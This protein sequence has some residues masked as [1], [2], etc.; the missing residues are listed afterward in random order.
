MTRSRV[1]VA[2]GGL[3]IS[4]V[5]LWLA[6]RDADPDA[7][8]EALGDADVALVLLASTVFMVGYLL[9]AIRWRKIAAT[10]QVSTRRFYEM[11]LGGL[12]CNNVLP[13]RIG[14]LVRAGWLSREAP[15]PAGRALGTVAL[16]R[17]CDV[18]TL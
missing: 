10:Q 7:V 13:V 8:R 17:V 14:E 16:D 6:V 1:L 3:A 11:A 4:A 9:G 5:F 18:V 12:A 2:L 15:M